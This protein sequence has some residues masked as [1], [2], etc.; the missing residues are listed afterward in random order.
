MRNLAITVFVFS[1]AALG[2]G[3]DNG[4]PT[5]KTDTGVPA[6]GGKVIDGSALDVSATP[7]AAIDGGQV[8]EAGKIDGATVSSEA[9]GSEANLP[10]DGGKDTGKIDQAGAAIEAGQLLDSATTVDAEASVDVSEQG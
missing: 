7:D 2:C 6:D 4:S 3:S 8:T 10:I 5:T 9:G 1:L